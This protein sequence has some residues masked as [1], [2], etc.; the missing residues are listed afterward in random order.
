MNLSAK[1]KETHRQ[2]TNMDAKWG[3]GLGMNC[4]IE[5][6]IDIYTVLYIN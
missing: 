6:E 3:E 2:R 4:E 1:Q 5:T